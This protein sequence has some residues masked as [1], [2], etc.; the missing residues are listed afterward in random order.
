[1][2]FTALIRYHD[3]PEAV[4]PAHVDR[5]KPPITVATTVTLVPVGTSTR[6][7]DVT[8]VLA[9]RLVEHRLIFVDVVAPRVATG[10][11]TEPT[12]NSMTAER[13][14]VTRSTWGRR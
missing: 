11:A 10:E 2:P 9:R 3:R 5:Q 8:E 14:A 13:N 1:L 6:A 7:R 12:V 4:L